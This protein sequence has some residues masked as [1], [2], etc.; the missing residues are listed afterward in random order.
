M[1]KTVIIP[2]I[3]GMLLVPMMINYIPTYSETTNTQVTPLGFIGGGFK[4][5]IQNSI[6]IQ[7]FQPL[8]FGIVT[9]DCTTGFTHTIGPDQSPQTIII[10]DCDDPPEVTTWILDE[11]TVTFVPLPV[12]TDKELKDQQ[13]ALK[14]AQKAQDKADREQAIAC[15]EIQN[16]IDKLDGNGIPVPLTLNQL[17]IDNCT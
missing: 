6:G 8:G 14:R 17:R 15:M 4:Y 1:N 3:A 12:L 5:Q 10:T 9:F 7:F 11:D 16:Q 13:N 2:V